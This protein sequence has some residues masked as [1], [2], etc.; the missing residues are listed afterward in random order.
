MIVRQR[1]AQ[2]VEKLRLIGRKKA[3][4]SVEDRFSG[5]ATLL[6][7]QGS[8][9]NQDGQKQDEVGHDKSGGK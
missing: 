4:L 5:L 2:S 9:N 6:E 7:N 8:D 3:F 1:L